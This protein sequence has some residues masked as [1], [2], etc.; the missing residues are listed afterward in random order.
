[1]NTTNNMT[2]PSTTTPIDPIEALEKR[3]DDLKSNPE[4]SAG[5]FGF[6]YA[7]EEEEGK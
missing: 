7:I 1:M 4:K 5:A 2:T 3:L 6:S